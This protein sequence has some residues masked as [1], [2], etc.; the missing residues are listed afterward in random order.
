ML[1]PIPENQWLGTNKPRKLGPKLADLGSLINPLQ[2][3][4]QAVELNLKLM[5]WRIAPDIDLEIIKTKV[6][7]LGAG[8][9]GSYVARALLGWGVRSITFVDSGRIS[10]SNPVRQPLFNFEDCLVTVDKG[11]QSI[12]SCREFEKSFPRCRCKRY[13]FSSPYGGSPSY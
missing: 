2:L 12:E 11:I 10:F 1:L 3:A 4:E 5:K 7:L 8:T 9:L 6:L 13:L